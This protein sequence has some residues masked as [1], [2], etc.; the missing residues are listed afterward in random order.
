MSEMER[1]KGKLIPFNLTEE[2]AKSLVEAKGE[3]LDEFSETYIDQVRDDPSW[4]DE[5]LCQVNNKWYKVEYEVQRDSDC[6]SFAEA[7]ENEDGT[8]D[9]HTYH[10]NGGGHWTEVVESALKARGKRK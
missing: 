6:Y 1:N 5:D 8:I 2:V 3:T 9:F 10:Y 7:E 4:Y